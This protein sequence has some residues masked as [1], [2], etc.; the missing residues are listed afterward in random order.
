MGLSA[1]SKRIKMTMQPGEWR[2]IKELL[3]RRY[4]HLPHATSA[5]LIL[6]ELSVNTS[7]SAPSGT[8]RH[9]E[10]PGGTAS[11]YTGKKAS[12]PDG[13]QANESGLGPRGTL[14]GPEPDLSL[15]P[16]RARGTLQ[17]KRERERSESVLGPDPAE[18][19]KPQKDRIAD[20]LKALDW[21]GAAY[22]KGA[23][24]ETFAETL[25]GAAPTV[26]IEAELYRASGWLEDNPQRRKARLQTFLLSWMGRA[27]KAAPGTA[28]AGPWRQVDRAPDYTLSPGRKGFHNPPPDDPIWD[29]GGDDVDLSVLED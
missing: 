17:R 5:K 21:Y 23:T 8:R 27:A 1:M 15:S 12:D 2:P 26:N 29:M 9:P 24:A 3:E 16:A 14:G 7:K 13:L 25:I 18:S 28:Q 10:A 22:A 4:P 19:T 6:M 20:L 11:A